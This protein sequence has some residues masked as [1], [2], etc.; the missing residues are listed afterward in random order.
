MVPDLSDR[1]TPPAAPFSE[2][3]DYWIHHHKKATGG[4]FAHSYFIFVV[5]QI[6]ADI[7]TPLNE[8]YH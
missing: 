8:E 5:I 7:L 4:H 1:F 3:S 2:F 6:G